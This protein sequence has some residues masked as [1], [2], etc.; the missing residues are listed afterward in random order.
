MA[1]GRRLTL[2]FSNPQLL[3][4]VLSDPDFA[5]RGYIWG[6]DGHVY[7]CFCNPNKV[8]FEIWKK[9]FHLPWWAPIVVVLTLA[10]ALFDL[11]ILPKHYVRTAK[12]QPAA[13]VAN[14]PQMRLP[15]NL[16]FEGVL[17]LLGLALLGPPILGAIIGGFVGA[18]VPGTIIGA[19][20]GVNA[21]A[22]TLFLLGHYA[23]PFGSVLSPPHTEIANPIVPG[24]YHF[25]R[26]AAGFGAYRIG[27]G[28]PTGLTWG[29]GGLTLMIQAGRPASAIAG[30][31][32]ATYQEVIDRSIPMV[33]W[34]LLTWSPSDTVIQSAIDSQGENYLQTDSRDPDALA[35]PPA[36]L[37]LVAGANPWTH[38]DTLAMITQK[39]V[40]AVATDG[41]QS[42]L[43]GTH[44]QT[45]PG[46]ET[47]MFLDPI[48]RYGFK[49]VP[50]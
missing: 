2:P 44:D 14:G 28:E 5:K 8:R 30:P 25:G 33:L 35:E 48:Q 29:S 46:L 6:F 36:G 41:S 50:E 38:G 24:T 19:I 11:L 27:P 39:V 31:A 20:V 3:S 40:D 43:L 10:I 23:T 32:G 49:C 12:E 42:A 34:G 45:C 47:T 9:S 13:V 18:L 17:A 7:Y 37:I 26:T 4:I 21:A 22:L 1:F 16:Q 15:R